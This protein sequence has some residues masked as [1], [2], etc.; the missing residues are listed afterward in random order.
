[1]NNKLKD[2]LA[3]TIVIGI[4]VAS[5]SAIICIIYLLGGRV[6]FSNPIDKALEQKCLKLEQQ[7][8]D[9][10]HFLYSEENPGGFYVTYT[11][12]KMCLEEFNIVI[13]SPVK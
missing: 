11:E 12:A 7:A 1:M 4:F 13:N 2:I 8:K 3:V 5:I 6:D 10:K 9:N